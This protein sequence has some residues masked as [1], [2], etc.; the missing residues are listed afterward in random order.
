MPGRA[1]AQQTGRIAVRNT[2]LAHP[3]DV[4]AP[5]W[6]SVLELATRIPLLVLPL[7]DFIGNRLRP[8]Q[9]RSL[10]ASK[11]PHGRRMHQAPFG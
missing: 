10:P 4:R 11:E 9:R 6:I 5:C 7:V 8:V 1:I 2:S 3:F